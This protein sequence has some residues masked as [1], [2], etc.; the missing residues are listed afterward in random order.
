MPLGAAL[1]RPRLARATLRTGR[2]QFSCQGYIVQVMT[3]CLHLK[4]I[5]KITKRPQILEHMLARPE[6]HGGGF[7][8]DEVVRLCCIYQFTLSDTANANVILID[9]E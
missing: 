5:V 8:G 9:V 3:C 7:F 4:S 2:G 1:G 6:E